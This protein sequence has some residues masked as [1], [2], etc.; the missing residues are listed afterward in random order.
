MF[1]NE[2]IHKQDQNQY[3]ESL[4]ICHIKSIQI[5]KIEVPIYFQINWFLLHA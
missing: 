1:N 3:Y 5:N 2:K 4:L